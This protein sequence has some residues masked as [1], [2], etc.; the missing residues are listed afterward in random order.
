ML[1][2]A[3]HAAEGLF[4]QQAHEAV[5]AGYLL[6]GLHHE[7]VL[8]GRDVRHA[9]DRREL[10]LV[11]RDLIVL[12]LGRDADLPEFLVHL[13]HEGRDTL[14]DLSEIV[15][16]ELLS[17]G[18]KGAEHGPSGQHEVLSGGEI[19]FVDEEV[20]LLGTDRGDDAAGCRVAEGLENAERLGAD[21]LH[22]PEERG[23][24][25]EGLAVIGDEGGR[26]DES[27]AGAFLVEIGG[28]RH[29]PCGVAAGLEGGAKAARGEARR[30]GFALDELL[31]REFE[32]RP[33]VV[34]G[35]NE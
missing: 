4:V 10:E 20:F 7:M 19:L 31:A 22:R 5:V 15:I 28:A 13:D 9:V 23:L 16:L 1:A 18:R 12:G 11:R 34:R 33:A 14:G 21:R 6:E 8:V 3:V 25:V 2:R 26:D 30:V 32:N 29:V 24:L 17:L 27:L 35:G